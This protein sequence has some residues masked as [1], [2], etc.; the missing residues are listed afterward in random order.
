MTQDGTT[1]VT[2]VIFPERANHYGTLFGG[3]AMA[4]MAK[5]AFIAASRRAQSDVVIA[6]SNRIAFIAPVRV[7]EV[8]ELRAEITRMGMASMTVMVTGQSQNLK[9]GRHRA[10]L[11]GEFDMVAVDAQGKPCTM[12]SI[13]QGKETLDE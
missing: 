4:L 13:S 8:L 6:A 7:G 5:A 3:E 11:T 12:N 2:E 1:I 10:V 9:S